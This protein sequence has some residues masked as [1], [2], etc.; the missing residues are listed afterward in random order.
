MPKAKHP[1]RQLR[2]ATPHGT[3]S[4]F[5][6]FLGVPVSVI[7]AVEGGRARLT[8][9][10]AARVRELTGADDVELLRGADGVAVT[11]AGRRY[12]AE[13]FA[14]WQGS[15]GQ[16]QDRVRREDQERAWREGWRRLA[17]QAEG[18]E[19]EVGQ[20]AVDDFLVPWQSCEF[21]SADAR[22]WKNLPASLQ[23]LTGWSPGLALPPRVRLTLAVQSAPVWNPEGAPPGFAAANAE[24]FPPCYFTVAAGSGGCR[25]A[26]AFWKAMCRE[27]AIHSDTGQPL[28]ETPT[29]NWRG[30][31]RSLPDRC[32]P[33]AVFAG[34]DLDDAAD[35]RG[36]LFSRGGILCGRAGGGMADETLRFIEEHSE[37]AGSPAG[38][39]LFASLE[40]GT[41]S[42]LGSLL[43]E[44]LRTRFPSVP[45][46]VIG[47]LPVSGVS[48]EPA[49]PLHIALAMQAIRRHAGAAL[50]FSNDHLLAQAQKFWGLRSPGYAEA[51]LLIAE[52]LAALTAPLRF[53]GTDA[54]PVD[55]AEIIACFPPG[56]DGAMPLLTA[57]CWPLA[58][59]TD[60]RLKTITLP[61]LMERT[62]RT[63]Q[64]FDRDTAALAICLRVRLVQGGELITSGE[65]PAVAIS[66]RIGPGLHESVSVFAPSPVIRR[67][68]RRL[69]RQARE[70][71]AT[72]NAATLCRELNADEAMV[73]AAVL[74]MEH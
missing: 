26:A 28:H 10:L 53:G 5:A 41:A 32:E 14:A 63:A 47:V 12:T 49:A 17:C 57:Q 19:G 34:L 37:D 24:L 68:L 8:P 50:L 25:M 3:Q 23:R 74:E 7:Q 4:A 55:L 64:S 72:Q 60:R 18:R 46:M 30:F 27:H 29:G 2:A 6:G 31:F 69:A 40:G 36:E 38:I 15:A 39:L 65:P 62:R 67:T 71:L 45:V 9:R 35:W 61:W 73:R 66:R 11:V 42:L 54:P 20:F 56:V 51:N 44:R 48:P 13:A 43:L 52:C 59:L 16:G 1:L 21:A 58:A 22:D 33:H 70:V